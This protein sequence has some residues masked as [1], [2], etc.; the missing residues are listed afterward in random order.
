MI[1]GYEIIGQD[2]GDHMFDYDDKKLPLCKNCN[3]VIDFDYINSEF[4]VKRRNFDVSYT[5]DGRCIT[6][7]KFKEFCLINNYNG[8]EFIKLPKDPDFFYFIVHNI[9]TINTA[10][11]VITKENYCK[12]CGYYEGVVTNR[13]LYL[14]NINSELPDGFYATDIHFGGG[15]GKSSVIIIGVETYKKIKKEKF[16]GIIY[17]KVES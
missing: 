7:L 4:K 13:P 3:Y 8:L 15:N 10:K 14:S 1:V 6:S 9:V 12:I 17:S 11:Q 16:K 2:N 5:Y